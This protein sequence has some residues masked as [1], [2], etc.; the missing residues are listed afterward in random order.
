VYV[1]SA[2]PGESKGHHFHRRMGEW[3]SVVQGRGLLLLRDTGSGQTREIAFGSEHPRSIYV[4]AG[5]AHAIQNVGEET[6]ICVAWAE[7]EHDPADVVPCQ[8]SPASGTPT[9]A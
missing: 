6:L 3:F 9:V 2:R 1:T 5:V 8:L 7:R 4:P